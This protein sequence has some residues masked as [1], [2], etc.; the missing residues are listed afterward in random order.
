M[1]DIQPIP[2]LAAF[3]IKSSSASLFTERRFTSMS[4][5]IAHLTG[6]PSVSDRT[7]S[8]LDSIT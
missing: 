3:R 5:A 7:R 2:T 6:A 4:S 8:W 1:V